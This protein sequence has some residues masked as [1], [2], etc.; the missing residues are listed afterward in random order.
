MTSEIPVDP[1]IDHQTFEVTLD[2]IPF[3]FEVR[4]SAREESY[5]L[6]LYS[7]TGTLLRAGMKLMLGTAIGGT[8]RGPGMPPGLLHLRET[9]GS[10]LDA[11]HGELGVGARV[12]FLYTD[13]ADLR[14][15]LSE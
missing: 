1:T 9:S 10:G 5:Y 12:Q 8:A 4:W 13:W 11:G 3:K 15:Y 6:D 2:E 7:E 14:S